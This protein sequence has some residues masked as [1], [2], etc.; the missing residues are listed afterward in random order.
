MKHIRILL[1]LLLSLVSRAAYGQQLSPQA[2]FSVVTCGPGTDLYAGF[3]HSAFRLRDPAL[4]IDWVYNYGTFDFNTPNFY[5]KF[6]RGKLPY[7]LS[8]SDF[9]D[10][11]YTYQL[12]RRWVKEQ[13]LDLDAGQNASLLAFLEENNRPENRYYAYD[14]LFENC[15]TKIPDVLKEVLG[16]GLEFRPDHLAGNRT[17]RDLIQLNLERNSW[18]SFGI[19]LALGAKIDREAPTEGYMFLPHY[20]REQMDNTTLSGQPLVLRE[21]TI[22][23]LPN[24][25]NPLYFTATP[26]F[27]LLLLLG[28]T[29]AITTIDFRNDTRSRWMDFTL[30]LLSGGSGVVLFFL[31]FFTDHSTTVWNANLLW[32]FPPNL[33]WAFLLLRKKR[34]GAQTRKYLYLLLGLLGLCFP[35]W[36]A[37]VQ[38]F[39]PLLVV[40]WAALGI[41]YAYLVRYLKAAS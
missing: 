32:A 17:Y 27:W 31:W 13:L 33:V 7:A 25:E 6:A 38:A 5:V 21:R 19:D 12:E 34:P 30:F 35:L 1:L 18:S 39:S 15:A 24:P 37:G 8:K 36:I 4:G 28:F 23:D 2:Q 29:L 26:L 20:V 16:P 40:A 10:F 14:F 22:L 11:L 9:A 41:R 3:G